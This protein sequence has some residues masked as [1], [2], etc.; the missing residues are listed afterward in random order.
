MKMVKSNVVIFLMMVVIL[1]TG[2]VNNTPEAVSEHNHESGIS[3]TCPMH[4]QV[5]QTSPGHCPVCGMDLVPKTKV[6]AN[7][8]AIMLTETQ[9][10]LANISTGK[11]KQ[12]NLL[13]THTVN[14]SIQVNEM[15]S[16]VLNTR[17]S[18]RIEKLFF[19][20]TGHVIQKGKP[21]FTLYSEG[22]LTLQR[23]Y[24]MLL[25]QVEKSGSDS[26]RYQSF[27]DAAERK[28]L[29]YG[30]ETRQIQDLKSSK[31]LTEL[32]TFYAPD[33][34]LI[35]NVQVTEG[36][37]VQEGQALFTI[38]DISSL[39]VE[40]ELYPGETDFVNIG[41]KV[42]VRTENATVE[43]KVIFLSPAYKNNTQILLMRAVIENKQGD[44]FPGMN[45]QVLFTSS[46]KTTLAV[47][48]DAVIRNEK[49]AQL[50]IKVDMNTFEPRAVKTGSETADLIE[51]TSGINEEEDVVLSGAYLLYSEMILKSGSD[52]TDHHH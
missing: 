25:Q 50:F 44:I 26:S 12:T 8:H 36:Q 40:A 14:A 5:I 13:E 45:A 48:L 51:I 23:E 42:K 28:L 46:S 1:L 4:P 39:W 7:D 21:L 29:L 34:G 33:S 32:I 24:L 37:Y 15:Q 6:D 18:G 22:L 17:S 47:P 43:A 35:T 41:D 20:E 19:K 9:V 11:V 3:Y 27:V 52:P 10:K 31:R 16:K 49:G 30:L 38:E 2:C